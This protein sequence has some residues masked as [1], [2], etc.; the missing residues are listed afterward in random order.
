MTAAELFTRADAEMAAGNEAAAVMLY[1]QAAE[2][3]RRDFEVTPADK[4]KTRGILA[5]SH[6]SLL[7]KAR[8]YGAA[9]AAVDG[10]LVMPELLPGARRQLEE[11][12]DAITRSPHTSLPAP[13]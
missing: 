9:A 7:Y 11:L 3:E 6:A 10:Y 5:V 13:D 1:R 8:L 4:P 12:R 2:L